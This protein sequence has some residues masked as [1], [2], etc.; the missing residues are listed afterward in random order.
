MEKRTENPAPKPVLLSGIQPSGHLMLGNY[1]GA[2]KN[3]VALQDRYSCLYMLVD[4]HAITVRQDPVEL[5]KRCL[6][7]LGLYLA[8]GIDPAKSLI[9]VQSHVPAHA[10]LTWILNCYTYMGELERMTQFKDK[11]KRHRA[12]VNAG[13]FTYPVLMAA[14]ILLYQTSLVPVG[15]DQRQHLEI[16]RDIAGRFNHIYGETFTIPEAYIPEVGARIMS[17]QDPAKKMSKSDDNSRNFI[18]LLDPPDLIRSKLR[19]AVTDCGAGICYSPDQPAVSNL[20]SIHSALSGESYASMEA[21]F[22]GQGYAQFK[23]ELAELVVE[24]LRPVQQKFKEIMTDRGGLQKILER[25]AEEA[26]RRSR[27]TMAKVYR[28]V[29]FIDAPH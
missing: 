21:R 26:N 6:E 13:L 16:T 1:V 27:K 17:L 23:E 14:D 18:A 28:R 4:M 5:R 12:N 24:A 29:G 2:L 7:F 20:M 19:K 15:D 3:W 8:C 10:E 22:Q 25:G 9:F 11:S